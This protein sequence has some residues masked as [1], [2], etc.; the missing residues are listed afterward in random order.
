MRGGVYS[1]FVVR[2]IGSLTGHEAVNGYTKSTSA[3]S[4]FHFRVA[5]ASGKVIFRTNDAVA[6]ELSGFT[7]VGMPLTVANRLLAACPTGEIL[8]TGESWAKLP[9]PAKA[10]YKPTSIRGE[11]FRVYRRRIVDP[12]PH[13]RPLPV[14]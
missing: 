10:L 12:A 7:M 6:G 14:G 3:T 4:H 9:A 11:R 8:M 5:I 1:L 13:D 2:L